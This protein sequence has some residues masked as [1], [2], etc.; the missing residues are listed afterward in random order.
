MLHSDLFALMHEYLDKGLTPIPTQGK[1]P[2][3][4]G[5]QDIVVT[6][7]AI[8]AWENVLE[9]CNGFGVRLGNGLGCIDYDT[10]DH[11]ILNR[12]SEFFDIPETVVKKG[13]KGR[14]VFFRYDYQP[15]KMIYSH[16][17]KGFK[18]PIVE[19]FY[20]NKQTV[21]PPT[22]HPDTGLPYTWVVGDLL[23]TDLDDLP[24][25]TEQQAELAETVINSRSL[26]DAIQQLPSGVVG[27]NG[28]GGRWSSITRE[29]GI[30]LK[31]GLN[32]D[33]IINHLIA[34]DRKLFSSNQYFLS[35]IK[36]GKSFVS[37]DNDKANA[38]VWFSDFKNNILEK[39]PEA[40]AAMVARVEV[41]SSSKD[42]DPSSLSFGQLPPTDFKSFKKTHY[43]VVPEDL[44]P[45][46]LSDYIKA[47]MEL[48]NMPASCFILPMFCAGGFTAQGKYIIR[49][50]VDFATRTNLYGLI[51]A[52]S[53]SRKDNAFDRA[54]SPLRDVIDEIR[55]AVNKPTAIQDIK[56]LEE[57]INSIDKRKKQINKECPEDMSDQLES[58]NQ[59]IL[60]LNA[61]LRDKRSMQ[62]DLVFESGSTEKLMRMFQ[63]NQQHGLF[64]NQ[65]EFVLLMGM[66]GKSGNEVMRSLVL[67]AA[68]G[69]DRGFNHR[70]IA[71]T[72]VT[73]DR[74]I[75][76]CF[77][78]VQTSVYLREIEMLESFKAQ[79]DGLL[80]RF[81]ICAPN[82]EIRRM[83]LDIHELDDSVYKNT[84]YRYMT[85]TID[86]EIKLS[87]DVAEIYV[88]FDEHIN[89]LK[90]GKTGFLSSTMSKYSSTLL[91]IA[92]MYEM[93]QKSNSQRCIKEISK[94]S[95]LKAVKYLNIQSSD[96]QLLVSNVNQEQVA[97]AASQIINAFSGE[98]TGSMP[99]SQ[100]S[101]RTSIKSTVIMNEAIDLLVETNWIKV[102]QATRIMYINPKA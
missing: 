33:Y 89:R 42:N 4:S 34:M 28:E 77:G 47:S 46:V 65:T 58:L 55:Q 97:N 31:Q 79:D 15:K 56:D 27:S 92:F 85:N 86:T 61:K 51:V 64:L 91:K 32:D 38:I 90:Q 73:L 67:K 70:T 71:G 43:T 72:N 87:R 6:H 9:G 5:W 29:A 19:I 3:I 17:M 94:E 20:G 66:M 62:M 18:E 36:M 100:I 82:G 7:D 74:L 11:E 69:M 96:V 88:D 45:E 78:G 99:I 57:R 1:R 83:S 8:D 10:D 37:N 101:R 26:S 53:G 30:L 102:D 14:T 25:I 13:K 12:L 60:E 59:E 41:L 49:P 2:V 75:M 39:D 52:P 81:L 98:A 95:M 22:V 84:L 50:K 63:D 93:Y 76:S 23:Y 48:S 44:Y 40:V 80:N 68:N 54:I 16:K 21:L 35:K 24:T